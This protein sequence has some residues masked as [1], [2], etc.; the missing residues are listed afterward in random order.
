M[1]STCIPNATFTQTNTLS[2]HDIMT[3]QS[4]LVKLGVHGT[5]DNSQRS[6]VN[7]PTMIS[8]LALYAGQTQPPP[9]F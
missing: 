3:L 6:I 1:T 4:L 9:G 7:T 8:P 2:Q 5:N